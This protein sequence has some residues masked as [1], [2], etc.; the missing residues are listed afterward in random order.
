MRNVYKK[1]RDLSSETRCY[2][3]ADR[4]T[5]EMQQL[6]ED[7]NRIEKGR[8]Y[9]ASFDHVTLSY[10]H[11]YALCPMQKRTAIR[12]ENLGDKEQGERES[13]LFPFG[14]RK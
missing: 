5:C 8:L 11:S 7:A 14:R 3:D 9:H 12:E 6:R 1:D 2:R 4:Q 13:S 10:A